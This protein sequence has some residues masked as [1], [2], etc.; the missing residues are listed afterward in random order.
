MHGAAGTFFRSLWNLSWS[1]LGLRW[2]SSK[3]PSCDRQ[4]V[5]GV[6][7]SWLDRFVKLCDVYEWSDD[8]CAA[9]SWRIRCWATFLLLCVLFWILCCEWYFKG[10]IQLFSFM[11]GLNS[12]G[13]SRIWSDSATHLYEQFEAHESR[14]RAQI[15]TFPLNWQWMSELPSFCI[16]GTQDKWFYVMILLNNLY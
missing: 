4:F 14:W 3:L 6:I 12:Y 5:Y 16:Y 7:A 10:N 1:C 15:L 13:L 9:W 11:F 8:L 2:W